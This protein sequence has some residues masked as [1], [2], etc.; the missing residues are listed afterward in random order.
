MNTFSC[1]CLFKKKL[2]VNDFDKNS[3]INTREKRKNTKLWNPNNQ[4]VCICKQ[5]TLRGMHY[6]IKERFAW[7]ILLQIII[8]NWT[9]G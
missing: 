7:L 3:L 1:C 5:N 4:P 2:N 6:Y 8:I 9:N